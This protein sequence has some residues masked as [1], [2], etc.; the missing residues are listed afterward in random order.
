MF[1]TTT[2]PIQDGPG[3]QVPE[4]YVGIWDELNAHG[5][6]I[7]GVRD[8]PWMFIRSYLFSPVDCL[9]D[10]GDPESCG[11][12]R[13]DVL[14]D[15]NPTL[16]YADRYPLLHPLDLSDAVCRP[17]H[18]RAVEGNVLVYHDPHHLTATY[19]RTMADELGRQ[20]ADATGWW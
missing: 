9:S 12:P 5:I 17:D 6:P 1:T 10:G 2:R 8:T 18:C 14:S 3:D 11:L 20:I 13:R 7:L 15:R 19:V 4:G 16:D